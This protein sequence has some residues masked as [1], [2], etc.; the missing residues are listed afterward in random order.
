MK[1]FPPS[2]NGKFCKYYKTHFPRTSSFVL[3][4]NE[5]K[6]LNFRLKFNKII[7]IFPNFKS[8]RNMLYASQLS[9]CNYLNSKQIL[10]I[11][12]KGKKS[13]LMSLK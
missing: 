4:N 9:C 10:K 5:F 1:K 8:Y 6:S 7:L 2:C 3:K 13:K 12:L 11:S